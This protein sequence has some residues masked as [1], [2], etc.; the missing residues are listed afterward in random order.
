M[1]YCLCHLYQYLERIKRNV[2]S[3]IIDLLPEFTSAAGVDK[4]LILEQI[5]DFSKEL[6][7]LGVITLGEEQK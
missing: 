3:T 1:Y 5:V 6:V 2:S 4:Q 7:K